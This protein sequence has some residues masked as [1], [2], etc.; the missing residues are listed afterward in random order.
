[1]AHF[2][3][4]LVTGAGV[5]YLKSLLQRDELP[6]EL[7]DRLDCNDN[8]YCLFYFVIYFG[9]P[10]CYLTSAEHSGSLQGFLR[11]AKYFLFLFIAVRKYRYARL[12]VVFSLIANSMRHDVLVTTESV[13][14]VNQSGR[15]KRFHGGDHLIEHVF[16]VLL[17]LNLFFVSLLL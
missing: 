3:L 4:L 5:T 12:V 2:F 7:M 11:A 10:Y 1:L 8:A 17:C 15:E 16:T 13:M 14:L 6:I 9:L